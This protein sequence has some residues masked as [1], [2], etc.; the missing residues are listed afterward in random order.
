MQEHAYILLQHLK[1]RID[2]IRLRVE[3]G[4]D[5]LEVVLDLHG[6][7]PVDR[8]AAALVQAGGIEVDLDFA[9]QVDVG[10]S[11]QLAAAQLVYGLIDIGLLLFVVDGDR[12]G[13]VTLLEERLDQ[14]VVAIAAIDVADDGKLEAGVLDDVEGE[15]DDGRLHL[16]V[17]V[18]LAGGLLRQVVDV[19]DALGRDGDVVDGH[20][21]EVGN[22]ATE[23]A[24]DQEGI[25]HRLEARRKLG[26][27]HALEFVAA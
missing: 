22:T 24:L 7:V 2:L 10:L 21:L 16:G 12:A 15:A 4:V 18:L 5:E 9:H 6:R 3:R 20:S 26:F 27:A 1:L 25:A 14:G 23:G 19:R 17:E 11:S 8:G 13:D